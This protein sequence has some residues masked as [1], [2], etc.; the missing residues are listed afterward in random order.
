MENLKKK[1]IERLLGDG[2]ILLRFSDFGGK[3]Q[4]QMIIKECKRY[5]SWCNRPEVFTTKKARMEA[6]HRL[7]EDRSRKYIIIEDL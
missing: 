7:V 4:N 6:A 1:S 2:Y 3:E 5:G